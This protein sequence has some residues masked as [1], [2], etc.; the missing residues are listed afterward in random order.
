VS[1]Y[2]LPMRLGAERL[3]ALNLFL[4]EPEELV[5]SDL[6]VVQALAD[7]ATIGILHDRSVREAHVLTEQLRIALDSRVVIEQSKG[8]LAE[9]AQVDVD[10]GFHRLHNYARANNLRL[11]E[12][13]EAVISGKLSAAEIG[14]D[15]A[16]AGFEQLTR[17]EVRVALAVAK[18]ATNR[19]AGA[20][21]SM[22]A[23]TVEAHLG[24]I[25]QKLGVRSRNQLA[26]CVMAAERHQAI[27]ED[28]DAE[29]P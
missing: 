10:E 21:L 29:R 23:R 6:V 4:S 5:A 28:T 20:A 16:P 19:D 11:A 18:G 2:A 27:P 15:H 7:L 12:V 17:K 22:S 1:V 25:Y 13:A 8:M 9:Q 26:R 3:G 14:Q 24:H